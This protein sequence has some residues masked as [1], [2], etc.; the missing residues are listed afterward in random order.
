M[1]KVDEAKYNGEKIV[2][3]CAEREICVTNAFHHRGICKYTW[4]AL[5]DNMEWKSMIALFS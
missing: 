4:S 5:K 3:L 2:G 1:F